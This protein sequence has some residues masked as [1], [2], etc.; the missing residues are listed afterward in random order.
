MPFALLAGIGDGSGDLRVLVDRQPVGALRLAQAVVV[1]AQD[2]LALG[3][4]FLGGSRAVGGEL[5]HL[6]A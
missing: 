5:S 6:L 1:A 2:L 4:S 3:R